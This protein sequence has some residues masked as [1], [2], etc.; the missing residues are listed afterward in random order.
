[1]EWLAR[2]QRC[3]LRSGKHYFS[4]INC[5]LET[6]VGGAIASATHRLVVSQA[7]YIDARCPKSAAI[8]CMLFERGQ[9]PPSR[10][11]FYKNCRA[12]KL[13]G[14]FA[15]ARHRAR[16]RVLRARGCKASPHLRSRFCP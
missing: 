16:V 3:P 15:G 8:L 11:A 2:W 4:I 14:K 6:E 5:D 12:Y 10:R 1:M 9:G 7:S 13:R